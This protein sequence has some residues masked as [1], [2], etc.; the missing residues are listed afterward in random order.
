MTPL[1]VMKWGESF[2]LVT[3]GVMKGGES[4]PF[5]PEVC[6]LFIFPWYDTP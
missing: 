5:T 1:G 4:F 3:P 6:I 2:Q